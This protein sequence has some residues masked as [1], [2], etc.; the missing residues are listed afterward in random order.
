MPTA[1]VGIDLLRKCRPQVG[2]EYR[3]VV[4]IATAQI[5]QNLADGI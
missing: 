5:D 1:F 3:L 2:Q 4:P